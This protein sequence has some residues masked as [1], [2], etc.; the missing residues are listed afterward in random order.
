[1]PDSKLLGDRYKYQVCNSLEEDAAI[2]RKA[3][4]SGVSLNVLRF[5]FYSQQISVALN[6]NTLYVKY[7]LQSR[8][9]CCSEHI[10]FILPAATDKLFRYMA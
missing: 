7:T 1:M 10:S 2:G 9:N 6:L 5:K 8:L 4:A 3:K